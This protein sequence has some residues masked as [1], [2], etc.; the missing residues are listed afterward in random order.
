MARVRVSTTRIRSI[1]NG[2]R[3]LNP[4]EASALRARPNRKT[5][6]R[7]YSCRIFV[8]VRSNIT[9]AAT[10]APNAMVNM[11]E[12]YHRKPRGAGGPQRWSGRGESRP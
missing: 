1:P 9:P 12:L 7:S 11:R 5:T 10:A 4:G 8:P 6:P 2:S 3:R